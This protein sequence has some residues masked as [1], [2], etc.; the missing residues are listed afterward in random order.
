MSNPESFIDEVTDEVRRD[1]LFALFRRYG[2]IAVLAVIVIVGGASYLEWRKAQDQAAARQLGDTI[3]G[4]LDAGDDPAARVRALDGIAAEGE[5]HALVALL[6]A[7]EEVGAGERPAAE[8]RLQTLAEDMTL[9]VAYR[10]LAVLK[11]VMLQG[12]DAPLATRR[13]A[14]EPL[15]APG[16]PY[17]PLALE[18]LALL[19]AEAGDTDTAIAHLRDAIAASDAT[20]GL[21]QRASQ[22]IVAL[23][24]MPEDA[25]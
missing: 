23:G 3:L 2:W 22:L 15:S 11:L 10:Q 4:A 12:A 1:R 21:R 14:L 6:A 24:G 25:S 7:G 8:T 18:Q 13:A 16:Q 5:A 20:P 19:A 17:R 9:P